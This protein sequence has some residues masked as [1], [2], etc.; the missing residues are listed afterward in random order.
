MVIIRNEIKIIFT[1]QFKM[2][3]EACKRHISDS[4]EFFHQHSEH[5]KKFLVMKHINEKVMGASDR[6]DKK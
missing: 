3:C 2:Y 5:H 1:I 6:R 4:N